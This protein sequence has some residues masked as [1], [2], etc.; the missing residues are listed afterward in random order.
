MV[1]NLLRDLIL[2]FH[3]ASPSNFGPY[4]LLH[5]Y[6]HHSPL[7]RILANKIQYVLRSASS[8]KMICTSY[9]SDLLFRNIFNIFLKML[10]TIRCLI[11][12]FSFR[13]FKLRY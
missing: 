5:F 11:V 9:D 2:I 1:F 7:A 8:S 12:Q 3:A 4:R 13:S 10:K 6:L